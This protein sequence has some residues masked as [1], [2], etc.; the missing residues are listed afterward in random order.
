MWTGSSSGRPH[1]RPYARG[2]LSHPGHVAMQ[3]ARQ[4]QAAA[5]FARVLATSAQL[6][7][8]ARTAQ[9]RVRTRE[10]G[11]REL[12]KEATIRHS[13]GGLAA[14]GLGRATGAR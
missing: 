12:D 5:P 13:H 2:H 14:D 9:D 7:A 6:T 11:Q 3:A 1:W 8:N 10:R 4:T